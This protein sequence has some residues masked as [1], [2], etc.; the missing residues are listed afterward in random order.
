MNKIWAVIDSLLILLILKHCLMEVNLDIKHAVDEAG[1]ASLE[2]LT[3]TP[4]EKGSELEKLNT[5][6]AVADCLQ[7]VDTDGID[8]MTTCVENRYIIIFTSNFPNR[9]YSKYITKFMVHH[10][11]TIYGVIT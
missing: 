10:F 6:V 5:I 9:L 8:P 4:L 11:T 3:L 1:A 7:G 2:E